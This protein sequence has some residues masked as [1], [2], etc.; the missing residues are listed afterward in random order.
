M[1]NFPNNTL[2]L[3]IQTE[4]SVL[5][6]HFKLYLILIHGEIISHNPKRK[7]E[8]FVEFFEIPFVKDWLKDQ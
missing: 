2:F 4:T 1:L 6:I 3:F 5:Y 8:S 7:D